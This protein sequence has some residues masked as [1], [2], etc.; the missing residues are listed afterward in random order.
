MIR[1]S[2]Y[3]FWYISL[4]RIR[5]IGSDV[6]N[7]QP[8]WAKLLSFGVL[9]TCYNIFYFLRVRILEFFTFHIG[10]LI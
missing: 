1:S 5:R 4:V 8:K 3:F 6:E 2:L 10:G 9:L 7:V